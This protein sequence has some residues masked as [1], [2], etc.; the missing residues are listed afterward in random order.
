MRKTIYRGERTVQDRFHEKCSRTPLMLGSMNR[1]ALHAVECLLEA[2]ATLE[3]ADIEGN[4]VLHHVCAQ[5]FNH[6]P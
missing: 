6:H 4:T 2:G 1:D 3:K 5:R